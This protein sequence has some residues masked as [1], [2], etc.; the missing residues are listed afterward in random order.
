[1]KSCTACRIDGPC[2]RLAR[3]ELAHGI[4]NTYLHGCRCLDCRQAERA[5]KGRHTPIPDTLADD[6]IVDAV[7]VER[8]CADPNAWRTNLP[9]TPAE[10]RAAGRI[11]GAWSHKALGISGTD[12]KKGAA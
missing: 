8:L 5:R 3:G 4:R 10:K 12:A 6:G 11:L 7:V 9:A 1:V 2:P